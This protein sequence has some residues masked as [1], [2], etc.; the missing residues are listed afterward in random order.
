M[1]YNYSTKKQAYFVMQPID[2]T[3]QFIDC[4]ND[5]SESAKDS[6]SQTL[7][8]IPLVLINEIFE[9]TQRKYALA[10]RAEENLKYSFNHHI[11]CML[12]LLYDTARNA[13][14]ANEDL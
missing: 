3:R 14:M 8:F 12:N 13:Y 9:I 6:I 5:L 1:V 7:G 11:A 2:L 10:S 4:F